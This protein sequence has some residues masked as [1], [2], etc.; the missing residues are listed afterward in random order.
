VIIPSE[1]RVFEW[2][3]KHRRSSSEKN[4]TSEAIKAI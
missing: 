4:G 3:Q 2:P 1:S